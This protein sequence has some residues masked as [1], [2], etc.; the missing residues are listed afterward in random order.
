MDG[1]ELL[2]ALEEELI[3]AQARLGRWVALAGTLGKQ[4]ERLWTF[5]R[6]VLQADIETLTALIE[7]LKGDTRL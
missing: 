1:M 6:A 2:P 4:G 7:Q 5:R 3:R